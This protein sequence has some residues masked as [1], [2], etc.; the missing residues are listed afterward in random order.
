MTNFIKSVFFEKQ[1]LLCY[2]NDLIMNIFEYYLQMREGK[3][4]DS[5]DA[6][7]DM[8]YA[9]L[10]R[11]QLLFEFDIAAISN[12]KEALRFTFAKNLP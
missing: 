10:I 1:A 9:K 6:P 12:S 11:E 7:F 4:Y 2:T 8:D 5:T 3:P